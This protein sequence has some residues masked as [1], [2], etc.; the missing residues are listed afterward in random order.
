MAEIPRLTGRLRVDCA[1]TLK[2]YGET[3]SEF[4]TPQ[5]L[6]GFGEIQEHSPIQPGDFCRTDNIGRAA[7][8]PRLTRM[9]GR[10]LLGCAETLK[11]RGGANPECAR[12][13]DLSGF[14]EISE[15][16]P[17]KSAN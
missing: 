9:T 1:E 16:S 14:G 2:S 10:L 15:K 12:P 4:A 11:S 5:D 13:E 6:S 3:I 7:E 17:N 8:I